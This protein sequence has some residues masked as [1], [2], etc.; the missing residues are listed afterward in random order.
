MMSRAL[1]AEATSLSK[2]KLLGMIDLS[3]VCELTPEVR[4]N[5][6]TARSSADLLLTLVNDILDFS[7]VDAGKLRPLERGLDQAR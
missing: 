5:L 7:K 6:E 2:G 1:R 4:D 3:L